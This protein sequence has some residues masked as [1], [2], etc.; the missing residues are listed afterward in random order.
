M[1]GQAQDDLVRSTNEA[2]RESQRHARNTRIDLSRARRALERRRLDLQLAIDRARQIDPENPAI[3]SAEQ[4]L[5][6]TRVR[7]DELRA[8]TSNRARR[9][10]YLRPERLMVGQVVYFV[11]AKSGGPIKIGTTANLERRFV[12]LQ[13]GSPV[14][15]VVI[16]AVPGGAMLEAALHRRLANHRLHGEW[17]ADTEDVRVA[18]CE[19][20]Q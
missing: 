19:A 14:T 4:M 10:R 6:S 1:S 17:F 8:A 7:V 3:A 9:R 16:G 15:L 2:F 18:I 13:S 12:V 5:A 11:Q 20:L